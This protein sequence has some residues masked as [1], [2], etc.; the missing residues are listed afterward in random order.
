MILEE[1][2]ARLKWNNA[3]KKRYTD[4]GY[5]FTKNGDEF[6]VE[7][8]HLT[9][10]TR[11][12]IFMMCDF[13]NE[14]IEE[15]LYKSY[16][17]CKQRS[18][19]PNDCCSACREIKIKEGT[20]I[21]YGVDSVN[22]V[23]EV[24]QKKI[25]SYIVRFGVDSPLKS[26]ELMNKVKQTNIE[27]YGFE[28]VFQTESVKDKLVKTN[29]SKYGVRYYNMTEEHRERVKITSLSVYG[30]ENPSQNEDVKSKIKKTNLKRY[31][32]ENSMKHKDVVAKVRKTMFNNETATTS[33]QQLFL[34]EYIGGELN[35]P[36][37]NC[38]LDIALV[39]KMI[40]IEYDGG[41]HDLCV[42]MGSMSE[43]DFENKDRR[44]DYYV[45][46]KGWKVLRIVSR[47]DKLPPMN[48]LLD[49]I[50]ECID[51]LCAGRHY[52]K[53]DIDNG[54]ISC[55]QYTKEIKFSSI[56]QMSR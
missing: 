28:N 23:E 20:N 25:A 29:L 14:N 16:I 18:I 53:I 24:K 55:S 27:R 54:K 49:L 11:A 1:R 48:E 7:I 26:E 21:K 50:K 51:Y 45:I 47:Q 34:H 19:S 12:Y 46:N 56:K 5:A 13:C 6:L 8:R 32:F 42:K 2:K 35:F 9:P 15:K 52:I 38:S 10:T 36:L 33:K 30:T 41:G 3:N 40:D 31:G 17:H 22:Q 43:K 37:G 44:R 4:L 39:D